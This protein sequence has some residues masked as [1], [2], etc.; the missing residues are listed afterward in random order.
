MNYLKQILAFERLQELHQL[1]TGQARLWYALLYLNNI[2]GW[3]EWFTVASSVLENRCSLSRSGMVKARKELIEKGYLRVR[4]NGRKAASYSIKDLTLLW[5]N[6][7]VTDNQTELRQ[8]E[9]AEKPIAK[10]QAP[11]KHQASTSVSCPA[12]PSTSAQVSRQ[13]PTPLNKQNPNK[14]KQDLNQHH[15]SKALILW[16][17]N[18]GRPTAHVKVEIEK[19]VG[20][21]GNDLVEWAIKAALDR[22]VGKTGAVTYVRKMLTKYRQMG[23][24][25]VEQAEEEATKF[26]QNRNA[27]QR[28]HAWQRPKRVEKQPSWKTD[29]QPVHITTPEQA[30]EVKALIAQ[31]HEDEEE[32]TD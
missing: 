13:A 12:N 17:R 19:W 11:V 24:K 22:S 29:E 7:D 27:N 8:E 23:I 18:W 25:T 1:S 28:H 31:L 21:F 10:A 3:Q 14:T 6:D 15:P 2:S 9:V 32:T 20:N 26:Q 16:N 30:A 4:S 5:Q